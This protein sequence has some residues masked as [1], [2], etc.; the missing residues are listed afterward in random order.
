MRTRTF[1]KHIFALSSGNV[2]EAIIRGIKKGL[3][4]G[5]RDLD[6]LSANVCAYDY[7]QSDAIK[8]DVQVHT[9]IIADERQITKGL[10]WLRDKRRNRHLT[11]EQQGVLEDFHRFRL[12]GF[13]IPVGRRYDHLPVYQVEASDGRHFNYMAT[14]WQTQ[15]FGGKRIPITIFSDDDLGL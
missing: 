13:R 3:N 6:G 10:E 1:E 4:E 14:P 2:S 12:V 8:I 15:A 9:P 11:P 5:A 7:G